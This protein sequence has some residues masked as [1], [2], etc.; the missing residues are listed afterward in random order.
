VNVEPA[1][2]RL[3][4]F[5]KGW[6]AGALLIAA[7]SANASSCDSVARTLSSTQKAALAATVA[8]Q[9]QT[10]S[11]KIL[12][13]YHVGN[14]SLYSV[15]TPGTGESF[16]FY[17]GDPSSK[18]YVALWTRSGTKATQSELRTWAR[19]NVPGVPESLAKC[20]AW[21]GSAGR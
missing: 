21:S 2:E 20:F 12:H 5:A 6:F 16:L 11:A 4:N 9:L 14:W 1:Q 3:C 8:E 19:M 17:R 15:D 13:A 18:Q 10:A 7:C